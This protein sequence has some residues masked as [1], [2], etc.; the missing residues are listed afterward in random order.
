M[1]NLSGKTALVT[2]TSRGI[3]RASALALARMGAQILVH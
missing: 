3:G 2:G 1:V